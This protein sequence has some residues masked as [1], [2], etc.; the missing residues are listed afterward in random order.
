MLLLDVAMECDQLQ[1]S[2]ALH[3]LRGSTITYVRAALRDSTSVMARV[4]Y[5]PESPSDPPTLM[6]AIA[7]LESATASIDS[8][9]SS[10]DWEV[11]EGQRLR[12]ALW[13]S[14]DDTDWDR[15][16]ALSDLGQQLRD[17]SVRASLRGDYPRAWLEIERLAQVCLLVAEP[18]SLLTSLLTRSRIEGLVSVILA[19]LTE[20]PPPPG[21]ARR[22]AEK[23]HALE[24]A[25]D[26]KRPLVGELL[27]SEARLRAEPDEAVAVALDPPTMF[28]KVEVTLESRAKG[29]V[30]LDG[31]IR[32]YLLRGQE[33]LE[34]S[35]KHPRLLDFLGEA[36]GLC[37]SPGTPFAK[38]FHEPYP[39]GLRRAIHAL[40]QLRIAR[41]AMAISRGEAPPRL[42]DPWSDER[43]PLRWEKRADGWLWIW[44]R[45]PDRQDD[46]GALSTTTQENEKESPSPVLEQ[47]PDSNWY[48]DDEPV[49]LV[50]AL[51]LGVR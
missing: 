49:D 16:A 15:Y 11:I 6:A 42:E 5:E 30:V 12:Q 40:A 43:L 45:G 8:S 26:P 47:D 13:T 18:T 22:L 48:E 37:S 33:L 7:A 19:Q 9:L 51:P 38:T 27:Q 4:T 3:Y 21:V 31:W 39:K 2:D 44:S 32:D 1:V 23:L 25:L 24:S 34:L 10:L 14:K 29:L 17:R 50:R 36:K 35:R 20:G 46:H 28:E 41:V